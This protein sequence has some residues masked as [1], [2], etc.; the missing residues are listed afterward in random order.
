MA[1]RGPPVLW[2]LT[3]SKAGDNAQLLRAAEASGLAFETRHMATLPGQAA[4]KV[5]VRPELGIFDMAGSS[6]LAPPW[7]DAVLTMGRHLSCAALWI[8][9]Q[10]GGTVPI[11]LL[12]APKGHWKDF[13]LVVLPPWYRNRSRANVLPITM[14]LIGIDPGRLAAAEARFAPEFARMPR[15]LHVLLVGGD[16]GLRRLE[17]GFAADVLTRMQQGFAA[18][19]AI[20][21]VTSR[22][23]P[24]AAAE[25]LARGLRPQDRLFRWGSSGDNPYLGLLAHGDSFT[26]TADSLS[27]LIEVARLGKP[28]SIAEP[29]APRGLAGLMQRASGLLRPRDLGSAIA[30]LYRTGHAVPLGDEPRLPP[31]P[32]PDDTA[33]VAARLRQLAGAKH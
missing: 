4:R 25:A 27:M 30:L 13:D 6:A 5:P 8:K 2:V 32:L 1:R 24:A 14:P 21:A 29:P 11:A 33:R 28:L 12:N 10:S 9:R 20:H 18:G 7:P 23:T 17:P 3:G 15:P 22:R 16:M 26:V 19:G 31:R